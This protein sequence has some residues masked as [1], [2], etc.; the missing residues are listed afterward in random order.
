MF[1]TQA[2]VLR[3][4][5]RR[6][7]RPTAIIAVVGLLVIGFQNCSQPP[8]VDSESQL[9]TEASKVDFAYDSTIDQ[10]TYMS[11][12]VS[13][14]G[15]FDA[16]AYFSFRVGAYRNGGIRLNDGFRQKEGRKPP[17]KQATL[18]GASPANSQTKVQLAI[19]KLDNFQV[20]YTSSG[21]SVHGQDYVNIFEP[22]GT[23]DL[24][25]L[26]V[27]TDPASRL[28]YLRNGTVFGSRFEGSLY[29]TKN[30][31]LAGSIRTALRNDAF[32]AQT[33]AHSAPSQT[34]GPG[35]GDT[36][37]RSP[38]DVVE[39]STA[40][41]YT[42]VYGRGYNLKFAQPTD[43]T[44]PSAASFPNVILR[45]VSELNL[46]SSSDRTGL[47]TWTCPENLRF[48]IVRPEDS[49]SGA[50]TCAT[51]P[52]PGVL[53]SDLS[54]VRNQ[55]RVEDWYVDMTNRCIVPKKSVTTCYGAG[56]TQVRYDITQTCTEGVDPA[57]V[58]FAS[59]CYRQ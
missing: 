42:Q 7:V 41:Q 32:L 25:D 46:A 44:T 33:Y 27:R 57:C 15:T 6:L 8:L 3:L 9:D 13:E 18:L 53:T 24:S 34:G 36:L 1:D 37:A 38:R 59:V 49:R 12:A 40:N 23:M 47:S 56:V 45:E 2:R 10:I 52:D 5:A 26:L 43:G 17:E 35:T 11:C 30:P 22:L 39:G 29:F 51:A 31:T 20:M 50:T 55:L 48:K 14:V 16:G 28:R 19:R 4:L 21:S 58:S 54:I